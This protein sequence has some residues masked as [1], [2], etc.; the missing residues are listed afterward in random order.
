[1][2]KNHVGWIKPRSGASTNSMVDARRW[3]FIHPTFLDSGLIRN[4]G[5]YRNA[6]E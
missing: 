1:M 5:S 2:N 6:V 4:D 3:R